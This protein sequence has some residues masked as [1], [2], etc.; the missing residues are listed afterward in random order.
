MSDDCPILSSDE[1]DC[2]TS[3]SKAVLFWIQVI[4]YG[5][6][7]NTLDWK[8]RGSSGALSSH[9]A[10]PPVELNQRGGRVGSLTTNSA[11]CPGVE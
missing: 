1:D 9:S 4:F 7:I 11:P 3:G 10:P 6:S 2:P 8:R 5:V